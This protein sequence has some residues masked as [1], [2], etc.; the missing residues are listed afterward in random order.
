MERNGRCGATAPS[1]SAEERAWF[2]AFEALDFE[3]DGRH[4]LNGLPR[5]MSE[6]QPEAGGSWLR[7]IRPSLAALVAS[8]SR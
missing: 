6:L 2:D 3:D 5:D 1:L 4:V 8:W 7:R